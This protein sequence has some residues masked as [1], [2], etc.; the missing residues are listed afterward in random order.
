PVSPLFPY[1][2]LFPISGWTLEQV[3]QETHQPASPKMAELSREA[4]H[5]IAAFA[6][7]A[8]AHSHTINLPRARPLKLATWPV[9][10]RALPFTSRSEEHTSELQSRE[11]L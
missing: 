6:A 10:M 1:T 7:L 4:L 11:N 8:K 3:L 5:R 9:R 2:T